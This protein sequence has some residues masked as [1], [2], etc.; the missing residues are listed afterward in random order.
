[1]N[2]NCYKNQSI[3]SLKRKLELIEMMGGKC[4]KC[5]YNKNI[6]AL[7]FHHLDPSTKEFQLDSRMLSNKNMEKILNEAKKCILLCA[8]CHREMHH[9]ELTIENAHTIVENSE[10][11]NKTFESLGHKRMAVCPECGKEF[12]YMNGK[13]FCSKECR[14]KHNNYPTYEEVLEKYNELKSQKKV[15]EYF[16]LTRRIIGNILRRKKDS[17]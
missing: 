7:E 1:M 15:A 3:R 14:Y 2:N 13:K 6:S 17:Y 4:Q 5:G 8:N 12:E 16:H 9:G 11:R 10:T